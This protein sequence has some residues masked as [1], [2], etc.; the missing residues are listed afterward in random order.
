MHPPRDTTGLTARPTRSSPRPRG[1]RGPR[2]TR[3]GWLAL[4]SLAVLLVVNLPLF[5]RMPIDCDVTFY[6]VCARNLLKGGVEYRDAL[7]HGLP[8]MTWLHAWIRPL[9]GWSS[10][11]LRMVDLGVVGCAVALLVWWLVLL[12]RSPNVRAWAT[13]LLAG[14]YLSTSEWSHC[15]RDVWILLPAML[16]LTMRDRQVIRLIRGRAESAPI[17]VYAFLE[18]VCWAAAVWLKPFVLIPGLYCWLVGAAEVRRADPTPARRWTGIAT[19]ALGMLAGGL[20]IGGLGIGW[21]RASGAWPAFLDVMRNWNPEY[22]RYGRQEGWTVD[23]VHDL[24]RGLFPW[25]AVHILAVPLAIYLLVRAFRTPRT[26]PELRTR[27]RGRQALL[28]ALYLGWLFQAVVLQNLLEY[29]H[30][31]PIFLGLMIVLATERPVRAHLL[32][33]W[34]KRRA[35]RRRRLVWVALLGGFAALALVYHPM[36]QLHRLVLWPQCLKVKKATTPALRDGLSLVDH[37]DWEDLDQVARFIRVKGRIDGW[38]TCYS[39]GTQ[40][41]Y[42]DTNVQP[43]TRYVFLD[44]WLAC[45]VHHRAQILHDVMASQQRYVVTDLRSLGFNRVRGD[46]ARSLQ[47][48]DPVLPADVRTQFPWSEPAVFR[49]G[50]YTVHQVRHPNK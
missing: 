37:V 24:G 26:R 40:A 44:T 33:P 32:A 10:E 23:R 45:F 20:A 22:Y 16:A 36:F 29:I 27:R 50:M 6:D 46:I 9:I 25:V 12:G 17:F 11:P 14:F 21:L 2:L 5:L 38:I 47:N 4:A 7:E 48:I 42:L 15:Q 3:S 43:S 30:V 1:P 28:A 41:L 18:G 31:A 34:S 13:A 39:N 19:D 49:V 35:C 8:G